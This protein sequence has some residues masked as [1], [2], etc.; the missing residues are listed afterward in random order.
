MDRR[1]TSAWFY[2]MIGSRMPG[3]LHHFLVGLLLQRTM[4]YRYPWLFLHSLLLQNTGKEKDA[5]QRCSCCLFS[6]APTQ[7]VQLGV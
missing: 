4:I 7:M 3:H 1:I 5:R 2:T 6:E